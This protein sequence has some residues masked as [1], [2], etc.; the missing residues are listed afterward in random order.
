[1]SCI[2][3]KLYIPAGKA[4]SAPPIGPIL[5]QY[6]LNLME[7]CK[8]FNE[9]TAFFNDSIIIPV[10]ILVF[11]DSEF[12]YIVKIPT[13]SFLLKKILGKELFSKFAGSIYIGV[14]TVAQLYELVHIKW[15]CRNKLHINHSYMST[16]LGSV[17][18]SGIYCIY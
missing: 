5:G 10:S 4:S 13:V 6:R 8:D 16:V 17:K 15:L 9:Q 7:F 11:Q 18:S 2:A 12:E 14:L 3:I 1:M